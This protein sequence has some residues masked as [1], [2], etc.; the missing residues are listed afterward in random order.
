MIRLVPARLRPQWRVEL[1]NGG[2]LQVSQGDVVV[3]EAEQGTKLACVCSEP[4]LIPDVIPHGHLRRVLRVATDE[5]VSQY[6][7]RLRLEKEVMEYCYERVK[8]RELPMNL[9]TAEEVPE[10]KKIIIYFTAEGRIDFR[11]LVKDLVKRFRT[12]IEMRQIGVRNQGKMIGGIGSCGRVLCCSAF[13]ENFEPVSI[14]MAK[15]QGLPLNPSKISGVCGRLMCC[16]GFEQPMY[17]EAQRLFPT[18]GTRISTPKGD[19]KVTRINVISK[20]VT[21]ALDSGVE[22]DFNLE[23]LKPMQDSSNQGEE[24]SG[25]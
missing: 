8:A 12:R 1:Y 22:V 25:K 21:V 3:V 17:E 15:D 11:A 9:V 7:E 23:D 24:D 20:R 13:L 18:V 19:G 14:R 10:E 16:L 6:G 4:I 2:E 5:E